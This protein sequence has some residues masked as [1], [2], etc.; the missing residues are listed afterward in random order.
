[1]CS[2]Q[3][4]EPRTFARENSARIHL[5]SMALTPE[6]ILSFADANFTVILRTGIGYQGPRDTMAV[7]RAP[8]STSGS[9][10]KSRYFPRV[11]A[12]F[13][14]ATHACTAGLPQP[15]AKQAQAPTRFLAARQSGLFC[16]LASL[17]LKAASRPCGHAMTPSSLRLMQLQTWEPDSLVG[18]AN[19]RSLTS[20][21]HDMH[22]L[23]FNFGVAHFILF[24]PHR[25]PQTL[26]PILRRRMGFERLPSQ[27]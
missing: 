2:K 21:P 20:R 16:L 14:S 10:P 23:G 27:A 13:V 22:L 6:M 18:M 19:P 24:S 26:L 4:M 1:M 5:G 8:Q 12:F 17:G 11:S 25:D 7:V 15:E 3:P 9:F